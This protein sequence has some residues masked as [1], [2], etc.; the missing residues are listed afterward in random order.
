M[1]AKSAGNI[2]HQGHE[3][4]AGIAETSIL[5]AMQEAFS[6]QEQAL[7]NLGLKDL[8]AVNAMLSKLKIN[9]SVIRADDKEGF[10]TRL[11]YSGGNVSSGGTSGDDRAKFLAAC[12]KTLDGLGKKLGSIEGS[13]SIIQRN[14]KLIIK[15][16]VKEFKKS[17]RVVKVKT[18]NIKLNESKG[19]GASKRIGKAKVGAAQ[20]IT[21]GAAAGIVA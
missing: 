10:E 6:K 8:K 19:K 3:K 2:Y 15:S 1:Q 12:K 14:R 7:R 5:R 20:V 11:E 9:L 16:V 17:G 18:E 21:A 13:D 4:D